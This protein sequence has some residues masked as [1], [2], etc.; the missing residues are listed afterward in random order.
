MRQFPSGSWEEIWHAASSGQLDFAG[1][2]ILCEPT[3]AMTLIDV[4]CSYPQEAYFNAVPAISK[5]LR[6]FDIGG[7]IG[8]DFPTILDKSDRKACDEPD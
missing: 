8:I 6:W 1:G 2:A 3:A 7:N 4:D 5:A